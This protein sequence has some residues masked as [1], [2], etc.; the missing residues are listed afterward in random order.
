M[1]HAARVDQRRKN[2]SYSR[3]DRKDKQDRHLICLLSQSLF[4]F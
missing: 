1:I 2:I 4:L 3:G